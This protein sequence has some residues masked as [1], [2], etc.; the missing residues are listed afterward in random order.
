MWIEQKFVGR[1]RSIIKYDFYPSTIKGWCGI[2][3]PLPGGQAAFI[4]FSTSLDL[5]LSIATFIIIN[6]LASLFSRAADI[7]SNIILSLILSDPLHPSHLYSP[8]KITYVH[9][10]P[11]RAPSVCHL[12]CLI[13]SPSISAGTFKLLIEFSEEY[14]NKP[15]TVRFVS[16]MFHPN[17]KWASSW[18]ALNYQWCSTHVHWSLQ[19]VL[20]FKQ[21]S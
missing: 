20:T 10:P 14:P 17:G 7:Y 6:F 16:R 11:P 13:P 3:V 18:N 9:P 8:C 2:V 4:Q 15:P 21:L 12:F 19:S 1:W 5:K